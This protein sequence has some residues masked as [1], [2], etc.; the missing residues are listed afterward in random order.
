MVAGCSEDCEE[1]HES[2]LIRLIL[3]AIQ[4]ILR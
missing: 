4:A 1:A 3:L 2:V